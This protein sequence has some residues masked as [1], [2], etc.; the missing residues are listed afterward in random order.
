MPPEMLRGH[1]LSPFLRLLRRLFQPIPPLLRHP[2]LLSSQNIV[3]RSL[4]QLHLIPLIPSRWHRVQ[5]SFQ[6]APLP[7]PLSS[8]SANPLLP[9]IRGPPVLSQR[10]RNNSETLR[11]PPLTP[12]SPPPRGEAIE[13]PPLNHRHLL[14]PSDPAAPSLVG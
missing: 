9:P 4:F 14:T 7:P 2:F 8:R 12:I 13:L 11:C 10:R 6:V 1:L 3:Y 5:K